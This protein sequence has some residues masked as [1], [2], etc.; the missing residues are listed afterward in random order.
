[1]NFR[2]R[3]VVDVVIAAIVVVAA[4]VA[5]EIY[6]KTLQISLKAIYPVN[7][8]ACFVQIFFLCF[9]APVKLKHVPKIN[10]K[11]C[12]GFPCFSRKNLFE[13]FTLLR[14]A[15]LN[16]RL[17]GL[18]PRTPIKNMICF[19]Y[20]AQICIDPLKRKCKRLS[21]YNKM[22]MKAELGSLL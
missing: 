20:K 14:N 18:Q 7:L 19:K 12:T 2:C 3:V 4:V 10:K 6:K 5:I 1:M 15:I 16:Q 17:L 8:W 22:V 9:S 11:T 13:K 21:H